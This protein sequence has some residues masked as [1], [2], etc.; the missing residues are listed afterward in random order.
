MEKRADRY[1]RIQRKT[2]GDDLLKKK[3]RKKQKEKIRNSRREKETI[4]SV[5]VGPRVRV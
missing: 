2:K 3:E 1:K 5:M 4:C